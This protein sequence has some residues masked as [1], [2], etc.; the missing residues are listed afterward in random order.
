M[1]DEITTLKKKQLDLTARSIWNN[2][3][4]HNI[5]EHVGN[6]EDCE[7]CVQTALKNAGIKL[8]FSLQCEWIHHLVPQHVASKNP[9]PIVAKLPA[10]QND[11]LLEDARKLPKTHG[12]RLSRQLPLEYRERRQKI[13]GILQTLKSADPNCKTRIS[14]EGNLFVNGQMYRD[15]LKVPK[16][17]EFLHTSRFERDEQT[18]GRI[19]NRRGFLVC[20]SSTSVWSIQEV[21]AA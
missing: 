15:K 5:P 2:L 11:L 13:W 14:S 12:L 20:C 16:T 21:R 19:H 4:F 3:L 6:S 9:R 8:N 7:N 17:Q 10:N 18:G 1:Q